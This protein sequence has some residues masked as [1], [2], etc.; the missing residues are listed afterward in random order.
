MY[1]DVSSVCVPIVKWHSVVRDRLVLY[2]IYDA[3][4]PPKYYTHLLRLSWKNTL[5]L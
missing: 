4:T 3:W 2:Y 1:N 5:S